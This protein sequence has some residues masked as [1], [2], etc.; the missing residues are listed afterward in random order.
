MEELRW[1]NQCY[2]DV[3][4]TELRYSNAKLSMLLAELQFFESHT[5]ALIGTILGPMK[6]VVQ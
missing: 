5:H 1:K 3:D 6:T 4:C 2:L